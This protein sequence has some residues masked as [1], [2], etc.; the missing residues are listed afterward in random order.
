LLTSSI[1]V[2]FVENNIDE[3][4][5]EVALLQQHDCFF[6]QLTPRETV[7][8]A[9]FLQLDHGADEQ[10]QLVDNILDSLGLRHVEARSVGEQLSGSYGKASGGSLS[11]GE[12]RRL[13]VGKANYS[14]DSC[15]THIS[16][17]TLRCFLSSLFLCCFLL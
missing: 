8:L 3:S 4:S 2:Y 15:E 12:R 10:N 14:C 1:F 6:A 13:S 5:G 7:N 9:A 11:G 17:K 16:H